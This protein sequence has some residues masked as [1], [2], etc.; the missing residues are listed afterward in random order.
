MRSLTR[1]QETR[2]FTKL[3][4]DAIGGS[5]RGH[6]TGTDIDKAIAELPDVNYDTWP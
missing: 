2:T 1:L 3:R 6:E 4:S 5:A